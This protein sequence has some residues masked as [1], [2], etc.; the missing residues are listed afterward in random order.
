MS[1]SRNVKKSG[2]RLSLGEAPLSSFPGLQPGNSC[3]APREPPSAQTVVVQRSQLLRS[4]RRCGNY[5]GQSPPLRAWAAPLLPDKSE[6]RC[7]LCAH[8]GP[9]CHPQALRGSW[10]GVSLSF[11]ET[12]RAH[13]RRELGTSDYSMC[14]ERGGFSQRA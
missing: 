12:L 3:S 1:R 8:S 10:W 2:S 4:H 9:Q 14:V 6:S 11:H 13:S 7:P 5:R